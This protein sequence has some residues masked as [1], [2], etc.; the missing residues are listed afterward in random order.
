MKQITSSACP[1]SSSTSSSLLLFLS[2][3]SLMKVGHKHVY[4]YSN[5]TFYTSQIHAE[6]LLVPNFFVLAEDQSNPVFLLF[7]TVDESD[8]GT[9]QWRG[10]SNQYITSEPQNLTFTVNRQADHQVDGPREG[11]LN[12]ILH[13]KELQAQRWR[14]K[15]DEGLQLQVLQERQNPDSDLAAASPQGSTWEEKTR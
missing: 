6:H 5:R 10:C 8:E 13:R 11:K 1:G 9:L 7:L 2:T 12:Q 4:H 3:C 15:W 14:H